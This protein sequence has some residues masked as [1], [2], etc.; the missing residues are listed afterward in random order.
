MVKIA[1]PFTD[2]RDRGRD[3]RRTLAVST[4]QQP[5]YYSVA[6]D[7][8]LRLDLDTDGYVDNQSHR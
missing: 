5:G 6:P 3:A 4:E 8:V 1:T 7:R 2:V